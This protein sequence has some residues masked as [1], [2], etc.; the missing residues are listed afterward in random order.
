MPNQKDRKAS[1]VL[2]FSEMLATHKYRLAL[3][4]HVVTAATNLESSSHVL[5]TGLDL[6]Y[7]R[8]SAGKPFDLL[9]SDYNKPLLVMLVISLLV[10]SLVARYFVLRKSLSTIW[11]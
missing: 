10:A 1:H 7:V 6:F 2:V 4:Q 11:A 3:P 5:V 8:Y 9:N